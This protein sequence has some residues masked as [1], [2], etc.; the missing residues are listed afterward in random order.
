MT[1]ILITQTA[2]PRRVHA[3]AEEILKRST[4]PEASL[5]I[6]CN[7]EPET[8]G[9]LKTVPGAEIIPLH[10]AHRRR[11]LRELRERNFDLMV[12]FWTGEKG[13]WREKIAS[14]GLC[15]KKVVDMGDGG[16]WPLTW[17]FV[18]RYWLFRLRHPLPTDHALYR[19]APAS[20]E[21]ADYHDGERV[22]IIQSA[23]PLHVLRALDHMESHPLFRR[24]RFTLFCRNR[25][26]VV[27][28]LEK[29][30]MLYAVRTHSE[31]RRAWHHLRA[32]RRERFDAVVVFFT[33]D[34]SYWKIKFLPFLL[35]IRHKVV[36]NE[37]CDCFFFSLR[38]WLALMAHRMSDH[39]R[40]G[41]E[42]RWTNQVRRLASSLTK[43]AVLPFRF[44]WLVLV[45]AWLRMTA[46]RARKASAA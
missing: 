20:D 5:T 17:R 10:A 40:T 4:Y 43:L 24:P 19:P 22:L 26:E 32:L 38:K 25:P 31:M 15:R 16:Q 21:P 33:G 44:G 2:S 41:L 29:H 9:Y 8:V 34:R 37:N 12:T 14:L 7:P 23:E 46:A 39:S 18:V 45:W 6:L 27:A 30:P 42:A 28:R 1:R 3:R 35:G 36:F 11:I 13:Y